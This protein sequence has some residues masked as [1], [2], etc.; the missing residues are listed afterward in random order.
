MKD[1]FGILIADKEVLDISKY[2]CQNFLDEYKYGDK[3]ELTNLSKTINIEKSIL[4]VYSNWF[5]I[6]NKFYYFKSKFC[7]E[8]ILMS[9]IFKIFGVKNVE[10]K[11]VK[12]NGQYGIISENYR[13]PQNKYYRFDKFIGVNMP[14]NL[15]I[16]KNIIDQ[17]T[18]I[19][20]GK[21]IYEMIAKIIAIDIM[22][23]QKDR[24]YHNIFFEE[25]TDNT[26]LAPMF[27]N[28]II[29]PNEY[30]DRIL[31]DSCFDSLELRT[32]NLP[33]STAKKLEENH[34]IVEYLNNALNFNLSNIIKMIEEKYSLDIPVEISKKLNK[35]YD[36]NRFITEKTLK[37]IRWQ[38]NLAY[39]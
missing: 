24:E 26:S 35:S 5:R 15:E 16:L 4:T 19:I 1:E 38:K 8:E 23:G 34:L 3:D 2:A 10:F 31:Y 11:I 37:L 25:S 22:F 9:E 32:N 36:N 30:K 39:N 27:D 12:N 28:G 21:K 14:V 20:D 17:K 33:E 6:A 13:M 7:F 18:S 29:K